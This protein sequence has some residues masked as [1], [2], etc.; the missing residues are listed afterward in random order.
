MSIAALKDKILGM[1][2]GV[3]FGFGLF[4][5]LG[6]YFKM[7]EEEKGVPETILLGITQKSTVDIQ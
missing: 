4:V 2:C 6:L 3:F 1:L 5:I 7:S